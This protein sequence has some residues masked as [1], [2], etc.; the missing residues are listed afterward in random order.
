M[1]CLVFPEFSIQGKIANSWATFQYQFPGRE[2]HEQEVK[3]PIL[4]NYIFYFVVFFFIIFYFP[5]LLT[6]TQIKCARCGMTTL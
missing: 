1:E 2:H 6:R 4:Y 3:A 5:F